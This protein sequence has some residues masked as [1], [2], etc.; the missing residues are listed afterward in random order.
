MASRHDTASLYNRAASNCQLSDDQRTKTYD[1]V[2]FKGGGRLSDADSNSSESVQSR[3]EHCNTIADRG[4]V[5]DNS[6]D[7]AV[8]SDLDV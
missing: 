5:A 3:S 8:F 1:D 4:V 7:H 6:A 2:V